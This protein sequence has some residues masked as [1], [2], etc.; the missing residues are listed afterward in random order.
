MKISYFQAS[1]GNL[2]H[3]AAPPITTFDGAKAP[4][5][6]RVGANKVILQHLFEYCANP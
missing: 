1:S 3:S 4:T 6:Q 2:V 5:S